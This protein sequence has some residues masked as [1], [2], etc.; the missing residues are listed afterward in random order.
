MGYLTVSKVFVGIEIADNFVFEDDKEELYSYVVVTVVKVLNLHTMELEDLSVK[1]CA[2]VVGFPYDG[3][4]DSYE[5]KVKRSDV[6]DGAYKYTC[7]LGFSPYIKDGEVAVFKD[8]SLFGEGSSKLVVYFWYGHSILF[9]LYN[10]TFDIVYMKNVLY[11]GFVGDRNKIEYYSLIP[12]LDIFE[13]C[14]C[15]SYVSENIYKLLDN[16]CIVNR[17]IGDTIVE[18][19]T[20]ILF[21]NLEESTGVCNLVVPPS[22]DKID[23]LNFSHKLCSRRDSEI[24]IYLPK[25]KVDDLAWYL[26]KDFRRACS[27]SVMSYKLTD[28]ELLKK[29][30]LFVTSY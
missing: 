3:T 30:N 15:F 20:L 26:A 25:D 22:V 27:G 1:D 19:G 13:H 11:S 8:G 12:N 7:E 6:T 14:G 5:F 9:N 29:F 10:S 4:K 23:L 24:T 17:L 28:I 16:I 21:I 18:S 2:D